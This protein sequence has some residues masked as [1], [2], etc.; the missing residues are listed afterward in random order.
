MTDKQLARIKKP[1]KLIRIALK[2]LAW[3]EKSKDHVVYMGVWHGTVISG[4]CGVCFAGGIIAH[5]FGTDPS[6]KTHPRNFHSYS[7]Q[8]ALDELRTGNVTC[9]L[10]YVGLNPNKFSNRSITLY[11]NDKRQF[12]KEMRALARDLEQAGL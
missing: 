7:Q 4:K 11:R 6:V 2:D 9:A 8:Y 1:S 3:V 12:K 10:S 5:S